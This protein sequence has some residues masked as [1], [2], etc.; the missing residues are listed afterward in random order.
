MLNLNYN[1]IGSNQPFLFRGPS[2]YTVRRDPYSASLVLAMPGALFKTSDGENQF[3]MENA[4][5]D[6][7]SY[8]KIPTGLNPPPNTNLEVIL[9]ASLGPLSSSY[10]VTS[11]TY[12]SASGEEYPGAVATS[13][14]NSFVVNKTWP[15]KEGANFSFSSSFVIESYVAWNDAE[16]A[17]SV[18]FKI[19]SWKYNPGGTSGSQYIWYGNFGGEPTPPAPLFVSGSTQF[20]YIRSGSLVEQYLTPTSSFDIVPSVFKHYAIVYTSG[21]EAFDTGLA[22]RQ[23][24]VY[25]DGQLAS[26]RT[27]GA[28]EEMNFD[29]DELLQVFGV[30]DAFAGYSSS[31][32]WFNDMRIYNGTDKN[33]TGS[34]FTT[35]PSM[36]EWNP[37]Y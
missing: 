5:D 11:S 17:G 8:I 28:S 26:R 4:Y 34:N 30:V 23:L 19:F 35:P 37:P 12:F 1:I 27:I 29:G 33:Y 36:V 3:E 21:S 31:L 6:I 24:K 25:L 9:S 20:A 32:A 7:S 14:I 15:R 22:S 16:Q 13:G 10:Y 2:V 18:P